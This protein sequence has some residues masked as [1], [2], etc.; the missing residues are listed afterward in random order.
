MLEGYREKAGMKRVD[1]CAVKAFLSRPWTTTCTGKRCRR[2]P[3]RRSSLYAH[4][5]ACF[6]ISAIFLAASINPSSS[7]SRADSI[8]HLSRYEPGLVDA[9]RQHI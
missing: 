1:Y 7:R 8:V 5:L 2:R 6:A 3:W 4:R 9:A